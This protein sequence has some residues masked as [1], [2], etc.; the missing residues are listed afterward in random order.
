MINNLKK[1]EVI[2]TLISL[3]DK[4]L[5]ENTNFEFPLKQRWYIPDCL[6]YA[7]N[8]MEKNNENN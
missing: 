1:Q 7:I 5:G 6:E 4:V 8:F 3:R 2:E